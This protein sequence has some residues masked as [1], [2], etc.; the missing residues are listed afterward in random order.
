MQQIRGMMSTVN[1][2]NHISTEILR[3]ITE[4]QEFNMF[5]IQM[6]NEEEVKS[7]EVSIFIPHFNYDVFL[8]IIFLGLLRLH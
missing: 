3:D 6:E 5:C 4:L 2:L 8:L 1:Q 7:C